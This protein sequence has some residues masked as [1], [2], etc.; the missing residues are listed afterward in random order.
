MMWFIVPHSHLSFVKELCVWLWP[1]PKKGNHLDCLGWFFISLGNLPRPKDK[2]KFPTSYM[3]SFGVNSSGKIY[4]ILQKTLYLPMGSFEVSL[5]TYHI[6]QNTDLY[7][8]YIYITSYRNIR[9][10]WAENSSANSF[11]PCRW[12]RG[13]V[14]NVNN[15]NCHCKQQFSLEVGGWVGRFSTP[16][17]HTG[18]IN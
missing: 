18:K 11:L 3:D 10:C 15:A 17:M 7:I 12:V 1:A 16:M 14:Q 6:I 13:P 2:N 8:Y 4:R 9:N 5:D